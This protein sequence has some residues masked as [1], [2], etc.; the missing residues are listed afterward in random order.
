MMYITIH[1]EMSKYLQALSR[2]G[3]QYHHFKPYSAQHSVS[4]G[5]PPFNTFVYPFRI[6]YSFAFC[7]RPPPPQ[8]VIIGVS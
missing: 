6:R 7:P 4:L 5:P 3:T 2:G 8:W 1:L